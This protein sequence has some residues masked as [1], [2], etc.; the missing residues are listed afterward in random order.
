MAFEGRI[1]RPIAIAKFEFPAGAVRLCDG[2]F[3]YFG[4]EKYVARD[5]VWGVI[6]GVDPVD[7]GS[8]DMA[9]GGRLTMMPNPDAPAAALNSRTLQNSRMRVWFG[10]LEGDLKTVINAELLLDGLVDTTAIRISQGSRVIDLT[11]ISRAEKLFLINEG[12][13]LSPTFHKRVWLGELGLDNAN[14]AQRQ[15]AWG[16]EAGPRGTV[17][18]GGSGGGGI[19]NPMMQNEA[20][21]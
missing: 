19:V 16:T 5:P 8:G 14:G 21:I 4:G 3:C 6:S 9:P 17:Y 1:I 11:W 18:S 20:M 7:E 12:N 13:T 10:E 2:G 15:S